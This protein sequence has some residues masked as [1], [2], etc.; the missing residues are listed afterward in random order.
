MVD[1]LKLRTKIGLLVVAALIGVVTMS[2]RGML[3][4]HQDMVEARKE[5]IKAV[6]QS[7]HN[8]AMGYHAREMRGE[9]TRQEAQQAV[10]DSFLSA[11]YGGADGRAE[12]VYAWTTDG[13][14]VAHVRADLIGRNMLD[15]LRDGQGRYTLRDLLAGAR[16]S[17]TGGYVDTAFPRPGQQE[18][19]EKLQFVMMFEPWDWFI[20]TGIYMDDVAIAFRARLWKELAVGILVLVLL[21]GIGFVVAR[22]VLRQIGGEPAEAI[23]SMAQA[24]SGDLRIQVHG[25]LPGSM[26]DSLDTMVAAIRRMITEIGEG[27]SRLAENASLI[28]SA[29]RDVAAAADQQSDATSTMAAAIEEMTVSINHIS[30]HATETESSSESSAKLA[31]QGVRR[32]QTASQDI[33]QIASTVTN[34]SDRVRRLA[35]QARQISSIAA[36]IK[37]IAGQTNLLALNA[38]IEAARAGEQGRGFAVVADE[39]RKLAERTSVATVEIETMV[40]GVQAETEAVVEV[41]DAA[42]PQV[43]DGVQ[44]SDGAADTLREIKE[45]A[46]SALERIREVANATR[47]QSIASTSIAQKVEEIAHMVE[48][49]STATRSTA[50]SSE[51]LERIAAELHGLVGRFKC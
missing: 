38:A 8:L 5:L 51:E 6:L 27:A 24:A 1:K 23:A 7:S 50:Q 48:R 46:E 44:A 4:M 30:D 43:E 15:E 45:G 31:D 21:G 13:V 2:V 9:L 16:S 40:Q 14:G 47:E 39:V 49:T 20:G 37:E 35:E 22:N 19:V 41:M 3:Q 12:Y 25:A 17:P 18:P 28:G 36:V 10:V 32:V 26:L 42:L 11:R 29:S 33:R 34:A